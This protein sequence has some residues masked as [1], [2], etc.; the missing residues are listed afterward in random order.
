MAS[1]DYNDPDSASKHLSYRKGR[2]IRDG[3]SFSK[4]REKNIDNLE[5]EYNYVYPRCLD[6]FKRLKYA[7]LNKDSN[8]SSLESQYNLCSFKLNEL[9]N[10]LDDSN[11]ITAEEIKVLKRKTN[12]EDK[13]IFIN[14]KVIDNSINILKDKQRIVDSDTSKINDYNQLNNSMGI[15]NVI[16]VILLIIFIVGAAVLGYFYFFSENEQ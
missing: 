12:D 2:R 15:S 8:A 16:W 3:N 14:Q 13:N 5:K 10:K 4:I 7:L 6:L 9:K 1:I 11:K